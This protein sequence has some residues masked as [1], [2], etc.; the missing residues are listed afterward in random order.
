MADGWVLVIFLG[1]YFLAGF[2]SLWFRNLL[3]GFSFLTTMFYILL[4]PYSLFAHLALIIGFLF[5]VVKRET[6]LAGV[7]ALSIL[8]SLTW[9]FFGIKSHFDYFFGARSQVQSS[10]QALPRR[11]LLGDLLSIPK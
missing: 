7:I 6:R 1:L 10:S 4:Y 2:D 9:W 8:L 3:S 5:M 11:L